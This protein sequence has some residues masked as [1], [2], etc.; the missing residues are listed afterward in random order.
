MRDARML[1]VAFFADRLRNLQLKQW[2]LAEQIGVDRKTVTRWL[3]GRVKSIRPEN[4]SQVARALKCRAEDLVLPDGVE[5]LAT[6]AEQV[7]AARLIQ[8][9]CLLDTLEPSG[10]WRMLESLIRAVLRPDLPLPVLGELYN[11]LST[12]AW[13]QSNLARGE[14]YAT[15]GLEIGLRCRSKSVIAAATLN[16]ATLAAFR[17]RLGESLEGRYR[18]A[19]RHLAAGLRLAT[20]FP[21][22]RVRLLAESAHLENA[23][24]RYQSAQRATARRDAILRRMQSQVR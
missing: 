8:Q 19:E 15:R 3:S 4:L 14:I 10:G 16:L 20:D 21:V 22:D 18:D 23:R 11:Q 5:A 7:A 1:N 2:W 17:G 12:S 24:G 9:E 13:R 6:R